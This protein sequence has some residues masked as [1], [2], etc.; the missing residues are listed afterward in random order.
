M[1]TQ[2]ISA[3][4]GSIILRGFVSKIGKDSIFVTVPRGSGIVQIFQI[5][6]DY[7]YSSLEKLEIGQEVTIELSRRKRCEITID[8]NEDEIRG[9]SKVG[10]LS[11]DEEMR[12]LSAPCCL[13]RNSLNSWN[14]REE[15][16]GKVVRLSWFHGFDVRISL[17]DRLSHFEP[18]KLVFGTIKEF[19]YDE[20]TKELKGYR[21]TLD[22]G[23]PAFAFRDD[24]YPYFSP[25][26]GIRFAFEVMKV[27]LEKQQLRLSGRVRE[28]YRILKVGEIV[29]GK[30]VEVTKYKKEGKVG[31]IS[32]VKVMVEVEA[33]HGKFIAIG[34]APRRHLREIPVVGSILEFQVLEC[35][36]ERKPNPSLIL[37]PIYLLPFRSF[38]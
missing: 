27:D 38:V 5:Y 6:K 35:D 36:P 15:T 9:L 18:R 25:E 31:E 1:G 24:F 21:I 26:K 29:R 17:K 22:D 8:L 28:A 34:F 10:C 19:V 33:Q 7:A 12:K 23:T 13:E 11:Y 3:G 2:E 37:K 4:K 20:T 16:I 14:A 32:G 30:V